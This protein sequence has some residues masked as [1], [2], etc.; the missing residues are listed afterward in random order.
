MGCFL[1]SL[2]IKPTFSFL[3]AAQVETSCA[4]GSSERGRVIKNAHAVVI[5]QNKH[6]NH[7]NREE[8]HVLKLQ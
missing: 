8:S 2:V 5:L 3:F 7:L 4:L 1:K 6:Q